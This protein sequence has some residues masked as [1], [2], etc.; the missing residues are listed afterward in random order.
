MTVDIF[1]SSLEYDTDIMNFMK[2]QIPYLGGSVV[3]NSIDLTGKVLVFIKLLKVIMNAASGSSSPSRSSEDK[4]DS[5]DEDPHND[6]DLLLP[7][8]FPPFSLYCF[9]S[10]AK[11]LYP[12]S[13]SWFSDPD[14]DISKSSSSSSQEPS[15]AISLLPWSF[16][17][18]N[19]I[20]VLCSDFSDSLSY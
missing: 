7:L 16:S 11:F 18:S 2:V 1:D 3:G 14:S 15:S 5:N 13:Y 10:S 12:S 19:L 17:E 9:I 8:S 20:S 4:S 6:D